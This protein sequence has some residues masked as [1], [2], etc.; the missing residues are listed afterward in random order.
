MP[1]RP[2][3][4]SADEEFEA[5]RAELAKVAA[6]LRAR[7]FDPNE[8]TAALLE[9]GF[10]ELIGRHGHRATA[11]ALAGMVKDLR[12]RPAVL[13]ADMDVAGHA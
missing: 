8:V 4:M 1:P 6:R 7:G 10:G 12:R 2:A 11:E 3:A 13:L 5:A 9:L